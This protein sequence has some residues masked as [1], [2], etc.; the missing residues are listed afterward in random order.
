MI[1]RTNVHAIIPE[2]LP[3]ADCSTS[4]A[5]AFCKETVA[6]T[7]DLNGSLAHE[8]SF[9]SAGTTVGGEGEQGSEGTAE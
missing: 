1:E 9:S 7:T 3:D 4:A 2:V 8:Y 6:L 5:D